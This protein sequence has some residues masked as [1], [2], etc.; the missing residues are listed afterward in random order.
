MQKSFSRMILLIAVLAMVTAI[1]CAKQPVSD[2]GSG[3]TAAGSTSSSGQDGTFSSQDVSESSDANVP[4]SLQRI[5]FDFDSY[6]LTGSAKAALEDNA[7]HLKANPNKRVQIEG[8]CDERGSDEYNLVLGEKR[9][10]ATKAYLVTLGIDSRRL[11][12]I[13]FGEERP[14]DPSST[15]RAWAKNRRAEFVTR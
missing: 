7:A 11:S 6:V 4:A 14:L 5:H 13:S 12:V 9:A 8:H 15:E 2:D 10:R 1:G 3:S